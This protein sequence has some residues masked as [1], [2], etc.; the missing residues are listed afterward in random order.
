MCVPRWTEGE[1]HMTPMRAKRLGW[2]ATSRDRTYPPTVTSPE[3]STPPISPV[4]T[5]RPHLIGL[6][7][8]RGLAA[9]TVMTGHV[10]QHLSPDFAEAGWLSIALSRMGQGLT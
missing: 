2:F 5:V 9:I 6:D 8:L 3:T 7:G 10:Q 1:L 4:S